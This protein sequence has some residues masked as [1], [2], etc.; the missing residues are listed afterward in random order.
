VLLLDRAEFPRDKPCGDGIPPGTVGMLQDLGLGDDLHAAGFY[1]VR[2]IRLVSGRGRDFRIDFQPRRDG[3]EFLIAP[4]LRLDDLLY[5]HALSLGAR[6]ERAD[7]RAPLVEGGRVVGVRTRTGHG[8][9]DLR[10][11]VVV[12]A[13]GATSVIARSLAPD[14]PAERHRGVALRAYVE[15]LATHPHAAEFHFTT[16]LAPGYAWIFP[17][18]QTSANVGVITRTDRFKRRGFALPRLLDEFLAGADVRPRLGHGA[19]LSGVTTWQLPYATPRARRRSFDGALLIGDAGR[20]VDALTGEG[21]HNAVVT[22]ML[23][24][25][26]IDNALARGDV[27]AR[28]LGEFD[29]RCDGALG[30]LNRRSY[31][32]QKYVT[33]YPLLLESFFIAA[34]TGRGLVMSW[35]NRIS[36]DFLVR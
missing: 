21:I 3:A 18:G 36:T 30:A 15:G 25:G 4:R 11:R 8:Q 19:R 31:R 35:L 23:A 7:V 13:D 20:F 6:F 1:P 10:A 27:S 12:A 17:L 16:P 33:D 29:R 2:A 14:K 32:A 9:N 5:R 34:R 24:A 28:S 22:G 26:V